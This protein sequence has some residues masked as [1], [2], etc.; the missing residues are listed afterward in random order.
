MWS[1][2][3]WLSRKQQSD[4]AWKQGYKN[5]YMAV[6]VL[7]PKGSW[8]ISKLTEMTENFTMLGVQGSYELYMYYI[9]GQRVGVSRSALF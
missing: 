4:T 7:A 9:G 5:V 1:F 2:Y 3:S 6:D 8:I